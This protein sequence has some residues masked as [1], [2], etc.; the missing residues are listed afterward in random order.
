VSPVE[1]AGGAAGESWGARLRAEQLLETHRPAEALQALGS[2]L[3]Q[4]PQDI[5]A[6]CLAA[7]AE[8]SLDRP[9][10]ARELAARAAAAAPYA[11]WPM[12]LLALAL[13]RLGRKHEA[14]DAA[15]SAVAKGPNLWQTHH[16]LAHVCLAIPGQS[17]AAWAAARQA[18]ELGPLDADTHA[19]MGRVAVETRDQATAERA[20]NDLGRLQLLRKDHFGAASHFAQAA[21]S[22]V[23]LDVAVHNI[24]V[25]LTSGVA[26]LFFWVWIVLFTL[27]RA[28]LELDGAAAVWSGLACLAALVG[29][30]VWQLHGIR[31][32]LHGR[33]GG[34]LR[35]LPHRDRLLT[36]MVG[37]LI[38]GMAALALMCVLPPGWRLAPG[39]TGA[40]AL[41]GCRILI[42]V[43]GHKLRRRRA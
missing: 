31:P 32:A 39:L 36:A 42:G 28:A 15:R 16:T 12:R 33:L 30:S 3:A 18:V 1:S 41:I 6:L 25:A 13:V 4:D 24:D 7:R 35:L 37:L 29:L 11:E 27:G 19:M 21:A 43:R 2:V 23:R 14:L 22:D 20:R 38:L 40:A 34:Y 10:R 17:A 26:R 9:E 5:E 8:L